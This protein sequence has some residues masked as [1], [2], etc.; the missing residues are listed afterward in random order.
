M[1]YTFN[2]SIKQNKKGQSKNAIK[3]YEWKEGMHYDAKQ[4]NQKKN[5]FWLKEKVFLP[6]LIF[7]LEVS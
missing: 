7:D 4:I 6:F 2:I 1:R 5:I 3:K